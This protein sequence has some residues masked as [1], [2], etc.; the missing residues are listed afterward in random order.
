[1]VISEK[2]GRKNRLAEQTPLRQMPLRRQ[3]F[4]QYFRHNYSLYIMLLPALLFLVVY[5]LLPL[6]G[7]TIAF[8]DFDIFLSE[9]AFMS[10]V[11]S[12]WTGL[13]HF[14]RL[15]ANP[16]F[17]KV[18]RNTLIIS[19]YKILFLF[20]AP[21]ILAILLNELKNKPFKKVIQTV[22]YMPHFLSWVVIFGLFF[23]LLSAD[24]MINQFIKSMG[25]EEILFFS[26]NKIFRGL[27]VFSEGWKEIGW[28]TIVYLAALT[29]IDTEQY[30]AA[31]ID[32][33]NRFHQILYITLPNLVPIIAL[34][35][36]MR[37]SS[38]L[39]AGYEQILVMYNPAV[40]E[41]AD[42]IQTYVY[43]IGM[44]QMDFSLGTALGAF[45]SVVAFILVISC[46]TFS[47][48]VLGRSIW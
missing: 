30:E 35:L 45:E 40:Y 10:I 2:L 21:I 34:M 24:G 20:P 43:R 36:T 4:F 41:C 17:M 12:P 15:F 42:I 8:K 37:V 23:T 25:G 28:N 29:S 13:S 48:K 16:D 3:G 31:V 27:L 1:M 38:V 39:N 5:K 47:K 22:L 6:Y 46:N 11:E 33:A 32:G 9:N 14:R 18:M 26:S 19:A 7:L 44:G